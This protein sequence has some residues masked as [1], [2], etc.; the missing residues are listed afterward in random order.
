MRVTLAQ[1]IR[2]IAERAN[3]LYQYDSQRL[4]RL[5]SLKGELKWNEIQQLSKK[6]K[7]TVGDVQVAVFT[8]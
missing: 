7:H 3:P 4:S 8:I 6:F 2:D 1:Q 5:I